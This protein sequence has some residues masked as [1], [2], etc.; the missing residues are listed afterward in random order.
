[1]EWVRTQ[2][3]IRMQ[4]FSLSLSCSSFSAL[5]RARF[6]FLFSITTTEVLIIDE[7]PTD[8]THTHTIWETVIIIVSSDEF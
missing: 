4:Y 5:M 3:Y 7:Q 1:M 2:R 8:E 6:S